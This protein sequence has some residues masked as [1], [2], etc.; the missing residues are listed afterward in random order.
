MTSSTRSN[1]T[2]PA[3][4]TSDPAGTST[5]PMARFMPLAT[6]HLKSTSHAALVQWWKLRREYEDEVAM[7][8]SNDTD[9]MA[10]VLVSVKKSLNKRLL[11]VWCEFDWG[12]D[13]TTVTDE[14]IL[15]KIDEIILFVKDNSVPD[16]AA[17]FKANVVV[18]ME[19]VGTSEAGTRPDEAATGPGTDATAAVD[20][21]PPAVAS[22][23]S[24]ATLRP[25][26]GP[27]RRP[28]VDKHA[29][30]LALKQKAARA[31]AKTKQKAKVDP[32]KA[33]AKKANAEKK[34]AAAKVHVTTKEKNARAVARA[35]EAISRSAAAKEQRRLAVQAEE[36]RGESTRE[37]ALILLRA[38]KQS[39]PPARTR[40]S[41]TRE[42]ASS[43]RGKRKTQSNAAQKKKRQRREGDVSEE[44]ENADDED[45]GS[46]ESRNA[47]RDA[48]CCF[49]D[50][51][52]SLDGEGAGSEDWY[53]EEVPVLD[54]RTEAE[55]D[56]EAEEV[57]FDQDLLAGRRLRARQAM[58]RERMRAARAKLTRDWN[59]ITDTWDGF[60]PEELAVLAQD[61]DALKKMRKP[62]W[63]I[64]P[65]TQPQRTE[66]YPGLYAGEMW[67]RIAAESNKYYNQHVNDCVDRMFEK[68]VA[69]D[70][71]TTREAVMLAEA[72][73]HKRIQ[74][75]EIL[76]IIGLLIA[77]ALCPHKRRFADHW[78]RSSVGA[79]P[80]GT[81]GRYMS[82]ARFGRVMQNLH[83]T[84]NTDPKA[85]TDRA[86]KVRYGGT[87][88]ESFQ[89]YR[90]QVEQY[91]LAKGI[92]WKDSKLS[93]RILA[94]LAGSLKYG[95]AQWYIVKKDD[96][97]SVEDFFLKLE[98]EF[99]PPD[100]Q[101]RLRDQMNDLKERQCRDLPDCISKFRHLITQVKEMSELDKIMYFL[102]G[103]PSSIRE[104]V[105]YRRSAT[106]TDA[107]TVA[108][109]YDRSHAYRGRSE[110]AR[111]RP[112]Y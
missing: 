80:K 9:K 74:P 16:V 36:Q 39:S 42:A 94:V 50:G 35:E 109:D 29:A 63:N 28:P 48:A 27:P 95:A 84:D 67:R 75:E 77:R 31:A 32:K 57:A 83:F 30:Y 14:F 61:P 13:I 100:L 73:K 41:N 51:Y 107:I 26:N 65:D 86:W 111:D 108:L 59:T 62:G 81:F 55:L 110:G 93:G 98:K 64:D 78:Q 104:E 46:Y 72:K 12:V 91:F 97:K 112:R 58:D 6:P 1:P 38:S 66:A 99:V 23:V 40:S 24:R 70:D 56:A 68:Q 25:A 8:C 85:A 34:A 21:R 10:E 4:A 3:P 17:L 22:R 92:D 20:T 45:G 90:E 33:E 69:R 54:H 87:L 105:Q 19:G 11:E 101:E 5:M 102:R 2:A 15:S 103:L 43:S 47:S 88:N 76:H 89:L 44:D 106:L 82:K 60:T 53:T 37:S 96:V 79:V 18:D 49:V 71:T 7:R 52:P